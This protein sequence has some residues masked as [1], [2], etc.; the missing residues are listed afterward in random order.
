VDNLK[1]YKG[2]ANKPLAR[3]LLSEG[4]NMA[5]VNSQQWLEKWGRRLNGAST[6]IKNGVMQVKTSPGQAAAAQKDLWLQK[7]QERADT[8]ATNVAK[9]SLGDW[10]DAMVNK[11]IGRI[12]A[13]V[14]SAQA[15]KAQVI[16]NLLKAVDTASAAARQV[17]RGSLEQNIQ[18]AVTFMQTMSANAPK[19]QK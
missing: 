17:P 15:S 11:G 5:R 12:A 16:D 3:L 7:I 4:V 2:R 8:W 9:V 13:G 18:R 14:T 1:A 19:R 6:D 10:Q